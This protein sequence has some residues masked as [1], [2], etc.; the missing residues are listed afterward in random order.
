[1]CPEIGF[2]FTGLDGCTTTLGG[3]E[4]S[5]YFGRWVGGFRDWVNP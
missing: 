5:Q 3:G 2:T 4:T 1:M